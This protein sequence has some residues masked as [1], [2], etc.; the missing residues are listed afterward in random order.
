MALDEVTPVCPVDL[1][2][3]LSDSAGKGV[4]ITA[5]C[6]STSQLE[7]SWGKDG[8]ATVWATCGTK[9]LLGGI[10]DP[11]TLE[12][13]SKLCGNVGHGD[14]PGAGRAARAAADAARLAGAGHADEP[15]PGRGEGPPGLA[16]AGLPARPSPAAG[17]GHLPAAWPLDLRMP[18]HE[19]AAAGGE[20]AGPSA[21]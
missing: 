15:A 7:Q 9:V 10:S 11:D 12:R 19:P 2:V 13:T 21:R 5:V 8:A 18:G 16:A 1:P 6:H 14:E 17:P 3:M 4:L 20:R